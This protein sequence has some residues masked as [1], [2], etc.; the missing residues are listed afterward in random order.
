MH[1]SELIIDYLNSLLPQKKEEMEFMHFRILKEFPGINLRFLD[2]KNEAGKVVSNP[3]IGYGST[4]INYSDGSSK[5]F[6][7]FGIS[8]NTSGISVYIMGI[9]DKNYLLNTF[10]DRL[11][12]A[13]ITSYCIKF[14]SLKDI[15][16][17]VLLE[18]FNSLAG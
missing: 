3:N 9:E 8:A 10:G 16:F 17:D 18:L 5:E 11:G 4:L 15:N 14:K 13:T 1:D 12:K 7:Q 6:Y 2:G